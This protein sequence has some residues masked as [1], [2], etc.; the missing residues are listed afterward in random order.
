MGLFSL[1]GI[2]PPHGDLVGLAEGKPSRFKLTWVME[3]DGFRD[4]AVGRPTQ[5][6]CRKGE[7]TLPCHR[8]RDFHGIQW[9][10]VPAT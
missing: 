9:L 2:C 4:W 5:R 10:T 3:V 7:A 8:Y 1:D 6:V